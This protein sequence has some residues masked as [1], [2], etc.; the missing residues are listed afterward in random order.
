MPDIPSSSRRPLEAVFYLGERQVARCL[1][2]RG[3]YVI[4]HERKNEIV[5]DEPSVSGMHARLSVLSDDEIY[6]EDL[7]SAN[8][9]FVNG[10][11]ASG[12]MRLSFD[13]DVRL[14]AVELRFERGWLPAALF[15]ELPATFLRPQRYDLGEVIVQGSTSTIYRALD[16]SL[17][18]DV[19]LKMM[20]PA[21]QREPSAVLRFVR[22]VQIT[23]QIPH[24]GI[25]PVYELGL[26]E[27][28][29][30]FF[31][32]RFIEGESLAFILDRL[33]VGDERAIDRYSL[34]AL[35][36]IWQ[37]VCDAVAFAHSRGVVH[38]ALRPEVVEVGR[39]GP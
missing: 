25:L 7:D 4:G 11:P 35:L 3:R 17:Q 18:R 28:G 10:Q 32:T 37:K 12:A 5:V 20:L 9:T 21:S 29:R 16:T 30:L 24:P 33:A 36:G 13:T 31:T 15:E 27:Q 39:W 6:I 2:R 1:I 8:G 19:A 26:N 14:G 38:N 23:G 22:E 34:L